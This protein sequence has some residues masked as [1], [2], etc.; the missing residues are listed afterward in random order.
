MIFLTF[1]LLPISQRDKCW[2]VCHCLMQS[3]IRY[4]N[5]TQRF[6]ETFMTSTFA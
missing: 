3:L 1:P 4:M 5:V 6:L 2:Q